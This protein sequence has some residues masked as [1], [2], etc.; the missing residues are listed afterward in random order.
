MQK[1]V[2]LA[3]GTYFNISALINKKTTARKA[4]KVF[5]SPRK[6][7]VLPE[8]KAYLIDAKDDIVQLGDVHIQTYRWSGSKETV[9][10]AHGWESNTFRWRNLIQ[11]L[12]TENYNI[13][14]FDAPA[15]G[16][17]SGNVLSG[18]LYAESM[19]S[20][21]EKYRPKYIIG[22]SFG[23]MAILYNHY[24]NQNPDIEKMVLLGAPSELTDFMVEYKNLLGLSSRLMSALEDYFTANFGMR[25]VDF[26]TP[27]FVQGSS[28]KGLLIHD[29]LDKITSVKSSENV[30]ANWK[31][32]IL[33]KTKGLGHSLH[34]DGVRNH[35]V[36]FLKS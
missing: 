18:P 5:C 16:H 34:Q 24:K 21:I 36:N 11:K 23:G 4:F 1:L 3:Y 35:V 26:S 28:I 13:V 27:K 8:Q 6:G 30:H 15:H 17:S 20:V 12:Q 10:L 25:F 29:E 22:H 14:A 2:L 9:L 7:K 32:S 19:Q 33:I 31:G